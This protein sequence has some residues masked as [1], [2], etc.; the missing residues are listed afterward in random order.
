MQNQVMIVREVFR[1]FNRKAVVLAADPYG[2][3]LSLSQASAL[4]D[5]NRNGKLRPNE[6]ARMLNLDKS[7]V[8]RLIVVLKQARLVSLHED[9]E[10]GRAK[11]VMLT[12]A[13]I[14]AAEKVNRI[15]DDTVKAALGRVSAKDRDL[16]VSAF[17]KLS[18]IL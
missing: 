8:S 13:G 3:G 18:E 6:L 16:I 10:D 9:P 1:Q 11:L 2:I 4:V 15:S 7:S 5:I 12:E 17:Q 14:R